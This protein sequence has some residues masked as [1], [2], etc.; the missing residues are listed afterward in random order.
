M[1]TYT[2]PDLPYDVSALEPHYSAKLL[3]LH[4]H[5][6][7]AAYV[8]QANATMERLAELRSTQVSDLSL[9]RSLEKSLAFNVS[10][11]FLHCAFWTSMSPDGGGRPEAEIG[12]AV[13][14]TFG[15][16][17][18]LQLQLNDAIESLQ[19][20]GWAAMVWEPLGERL[21][22]E[23]IYDHQAN[24]TPAN[25]PLL[26]IDGWEHAYYLQYLNEKSQWLDAFWSLVDWENVGG[27]FA[28]ASKTNMKLEVV[29]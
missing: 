25:I 26:V 24:M 20:S 17:D 15:S 18:A 8:K 2:L 19:G 9:L 1:D 21:V 12:D 4:H 27:R 5:K 11:H 16:F 13:R 22:V 3:E 6:H 29:R 10:G 28:A 23:Q 7:H 14:D